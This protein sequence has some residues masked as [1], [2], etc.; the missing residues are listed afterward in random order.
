MPQA[1]V[2]M[3]CLTSP[4]SP[5][6]CQLRGTSCPSLPAG[7]AARLCRGRC[8]L[9][10]LPWANKRCDPSRRMLPSWA[11]LC[12]KV[13]LRVAAQVL[14]WE[15]WK[16]KHSLKSQFKSIKSQLLCMSKR[17]NETKMPQKNPCSLSTGL[18]Q[19]CLFYYLLTISIP[20]HHLPSQALTR[21]QQTDDPCEKV[22]V[23]A[24]PPLAAKGSRAVDGVLQAGCPSCASLHGHNCAGRSEL[25]CP[26]GGPES[27]GWVRDL[28]A[29]GTIPWGTPWETHLPLQAELHFTLVEFQ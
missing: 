23:L 22:T 4:P 14:W 1:T 16:S 27:T 21:T 28:G 7:L 2:F 3:Q 5:H 26:W 12:A 19:L 9:S 24:G 25:P 10:P 15:E 13:C 20:E 8:C 18:L 29:C 6:H 17:K 11:A